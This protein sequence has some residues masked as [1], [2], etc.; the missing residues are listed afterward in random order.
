MSGYEDF[1][2]TTKE[3]AGSKTP[4]D[5][6]A[7]ARLQDDARVEE[8]GKLLDWSKN[9]I[10]RF[11]VSG[12]NRVNRGEIDMGI[13]TSGSAE[14]I[15]MLA[16]MENKF[17]QLKGRR[18]AISVG[19]L[20]KFYGNEVKSAEK[21][22]E[23]RRQQELNEIR[24]ANSRDLMSPMLATPYGNPN[25]SLFRVLDTMRDRK[26]DDEISKRDLQKYMDD[27]SR[28]VRTGDT[29]SGQFN[30]Q[31]RDYVENLLNNWDRSDVKR[32]RG[33][34]KDVDDREHTNSSITADSLRK[35]GGL[36]NNQTVFSPFVN[37]TLEARREAPTVRAEMAKEL[38]PPVHM[39]Q[40]EADPRLTDK[41]ARDAEAKRIAD[42][43]GLSDW[44]RNNLPRYDITGDKAVNRGEVDLGIR[45]TKEPESLSRLSQL[46]SEFPGL[47]QRGKVNQKHLDRNVQNVQS[48]FE[49]NESARQQRIVQDRNIAQTRD[50]VAPLFQTENGHPNNS[51]FKVLDGVRGDVDNK[52]GQKDLKKFVEEYDWRSRHGDVGNGHYTPQNRAYVQ[53]LLDNW[54]GAEVVRMRGTWTAH[55]NH[56]PRNSSGRTREIPNKYITG[57][58]LSKAAATPSMEDLYSI[59]MKK[60][61]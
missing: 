55:E 60:G 24:Q 13:R 15:N 32:L 50:I 30:P 40:F 36:S 19:D 43:K 48:V 35:A 6:K 8:A 1:D 45:T 56:G 14:D 38:T 22:E 18:D 51:L 11:D 2:V 44:G 16:L 17:P 21:N 10:G 12:D 59:Y 42:A 7:L 54:N 26:P 3:S 28:R 57:E 25:G 52:V 53:N 31:T 9:N 23:V 5:P 58:S 29:N 4:Q 39:K 27:Y 46:E 41:T 34:W 47:A 33:T 37:P 61:T 49:S 20:E